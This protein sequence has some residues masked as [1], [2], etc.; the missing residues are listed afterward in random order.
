MRPIHDV[1]RGLGLAEDEVDPWGRGVAK[2]D[3]RRVLE[4]RQEAGRLVLVTAITPTAHGEGKTTVLV[5]LVQALARLGER[6]L[7]AVRQPTL[8]PVLGVKARSRCAWPR[9][10]CRS[11]TTPPWAG[12][13]RRPSGCPCA[14]CT[15]APAPAS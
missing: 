13:R 5:G 12:R 14:K 2:V 10:R 8:G 11:R 6:A 7:G 1:A 9:P 3:P 4:R 15:C